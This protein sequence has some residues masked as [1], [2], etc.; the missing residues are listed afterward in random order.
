MLHLVLRRLRSRPT[1]RG[2]GL[3]QPEIAVLLAA[4][5][6]AG[7]VLATYRVE[8]H[9][10]SGRIIIPSLYR[11]E[12]APTAAELAD[13][14]R[15]ADAA[16]CQLATALF[17]SEAGIQWTSASS[18]EISGSITWGVRADIDL[19]IAAEEDP[20]IACFYNCR[21]RSRNWFWDYEHGAR[22]LRH[23]IERYWPGVW[24]ADR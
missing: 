12:E 4:I 18:V 24:N 9:C 19:S 5:V 22:Q 23:D 2:F 13:R 17:G 3:L 10:Y 1:G 14:R 7:Y 16:V 15:Q 20:P 6:V 21:L 8:I 11:P